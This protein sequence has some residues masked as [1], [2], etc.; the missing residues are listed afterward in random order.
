M[1]GNFA[2]TGRKKKYVIQPQGRICVSALNS[3]TRTIKPGRTCWTGRILKKSL[4]NKLYKKIKGYQV[5]LNKRSLMLTV[6]TLPLLLLVM[7]S[8]S[9]ASEFLLFYANDVRGEI[10]PCG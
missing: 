6:L 8:S 1:A 2:T 7:A 9:R 5:M 3:A 10:E 4:I